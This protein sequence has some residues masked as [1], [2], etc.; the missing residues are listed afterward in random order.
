MASLNHNAIRKVISTK[1]GHKIEYDEINAAN[2]K[3]VIDEIEAAL[4]EV[5]G[6]S[7]RDLDFVINYDLKYRVGSEPEEQPDDAAAAGN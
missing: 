1:Q 6:F 3:M 2:S 4:A 5:Y 7:Q